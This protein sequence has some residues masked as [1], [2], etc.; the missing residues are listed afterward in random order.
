MAI[1]FS[2][3]ALQSEVQM[4]LWWNAWEAAGRASARRAKVMIYEYSKNSIGYI[5]GR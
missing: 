4:D 2:K 1:R 3:S 5:W